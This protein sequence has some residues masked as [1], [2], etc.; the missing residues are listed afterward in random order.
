MILKYTSSNGQ[1]FDLKVGRIRTRTADFHTYTWEP[2]IIEQ[3]YGAKVFR[4]DRSP[5]AYSTT[6]TVF[7]SL[8]QRKTFLNI[9]HAAFEH[10][11]VTMTPGKIT[12]G[13]FSIDCFITAVS[14]YYED[15]WTQQTLTIYCPRPFWRR[16]NIFTLRIEEQETTYEW[17]D[18]PYGFPFDYQA[19]LPGYAM[20][21]NPAVKPSDWRLTIKGPANNPFVII[22]PRNISVNAAIGAGEKLVID[23]ANKTVMKYGPG[24]A[25]NLFNARNKTS[26]F[27]DPLPGGEY[28]VL[29]PG[30][31][32]V[33]LIVYEERS[34]PLWI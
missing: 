13:M 14:T 18:Y 7:G 31:Y 33:E 28:S 16:E 21:S 25:V 22:G 23:S 34:E 4:F 27:F 1:V 12:H 10:D 6:L 5:A 19:T 9:L 2:Q 8:Q 15:P 32:E 17:L 29:W 11:I 3:Q 30:T 26:D 24:E 20:V